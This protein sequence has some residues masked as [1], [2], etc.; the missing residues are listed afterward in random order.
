MTASMNQ[1]Q[2]HLT[3]SLIKFTTESDTQAK[4]S[5]GRSQPLKISLLDGAKA[6]EPLEETETVNPV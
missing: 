4:V 5:Q 3:V 1:A 2:R 6:M